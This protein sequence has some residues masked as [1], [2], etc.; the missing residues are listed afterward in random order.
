MANRASKNVGTSGH[1]KKDAVPMGLIKIVLAASE[2][3]RNSRCPQANLLP[4]Q[5]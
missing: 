5:Y 3:V 1:G 2:V 4:T